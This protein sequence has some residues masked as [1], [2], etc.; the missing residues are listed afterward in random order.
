MLHTIG[1]LAYRVINA[2]VSVGTIIVINISQLFIKL[3]ITY[4][5]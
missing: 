1:T 2:E 3:G 5:G 4:K